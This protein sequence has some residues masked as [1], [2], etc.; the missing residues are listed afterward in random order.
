MLATME[1]VIVVSK[2]FGLLSLNYFNDIH[3]F[4]VKSHETHIHT[5]SNPALQQKPF[6]AHNATFV[7]LKSQQQQEQRRNIPFQTKTLEPLY[8]FYFF[9]RAQQTRY[10]KLVLIN[11][12]LIENGT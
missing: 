11:L 1:F 3:M 7:F 9:E 12:Q 5:I 10:V 8:N 2:C 6:A 4:T